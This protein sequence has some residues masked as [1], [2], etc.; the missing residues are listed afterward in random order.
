M[1]IDIA[2]LETYLLLPPSSPPPSLLRPQLAWQVEWVAKP[3]L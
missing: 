1:A 3:S 2:K